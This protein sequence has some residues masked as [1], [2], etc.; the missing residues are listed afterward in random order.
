MAIFEGF[1]LTLNCDFV[2]IAD[3]KNCQVFYGQERLLGED[4]AAYSFSDDHSFDRALKTATSLSGRSF[5]EKLWSAKRFEDRPGGYICLKRLTGISLLEKMSTVPRKK[6]FQLCVQLVEAISFIHKQGTPHGAL[7]QDNV[8]Y[9][10]QIDG[11]YVLEVLSGFE[12]DQLEPHLS[13]PEQLAG[14]HPNYATDVYW[15]ANLYLKAIKRPSSGLKRLIKKCLEGKYEK[16]PT[17]D[18]L[19]LQLR[20]LY[21]NDFQIAVGRWLQPQRAVK[22]VGVVLLA[23]ASGILALDRNWIRQELPQPLSYEAMLEKSIDQAPD[24]DLKIEN[25]KKSLKSIGNDI[26][27]Y[28]LLQKI[29]QLANSSPHLTPAMEKALRWTYENETRSKPREIILG[30]LSEVKH[31]GKKHFEIA[32]IEI[33]DIESEFLGIML[34]SWPVILFNNEVLELGDRVNLM[35]FEGYVSRIQ[36]NKFSIKNGSDVTTFELPVPDEKSLVYSLERTIYFKEGKINL[37]QFANSFKHFGYDII[38]VGK[39][40][41]PGII[42]GFFEFEN[43]DEFINAVSEDLRLTLYNKTIWIEDVSDLRTCIYIEGKIYKGNSSELLNEIMSLTQ[44]N[45]TVDGN[46]E[47]PP[48]FFIN[49][50]EI[51]EIIHELGY[52]CAF[53]KES[54]SFSITRKE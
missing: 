19:Q 13:A 35:G 54:F 9:C 48:L 15:L 11:P 18:S 36:M 2:A 24:D 44:L 38:Q 14:L 22:V 39:G 43:P 25:L 47:L 10:E 40:G 20:H 30:V 16:R 8:L 4:V 52:Q 50:A 3:R 21:Q 1:Q 42:S 46:F 28:V 17:L 49:Y 6:Q 41:T 12:A 31:I 51:K 23:S 27:R 26:E 29:L 45:F 53:M 33:L 7:D 37:I 34:F 5:F 32:P